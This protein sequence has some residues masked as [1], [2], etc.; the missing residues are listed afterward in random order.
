MEKQ[1]N[2]VPLAVIIGTI[3]SAPA[4]ADGLEVEANN[5]QVSA[6][7]W[8]DV[9]FD[10]N[11]VSDSGITNNA[12]LSGGAFDG[13]KG[14]V[15]SNVAAG[16]YNQGSNQASMGTRAEGNSDEAASVRAA[17]A[18][19]S[20]GEN[21]A[22][23]KDFGGDDDNSAT[24][25]GAFNEAKGII[26]TNI[27]A[28]VS[29]LQTNNVAMGN[30]E[31]ASKL[32]LT[33]ASNQS[34]GFARSEGGE[35]EGNT[36]ESLGADNVANVQGG[37]FD[38]ANGVG[39][40]NVASGMAN[41]Q[42][43]SVAL[44]NFVTVGSGDPS[45]GEAA[46]NIGEALDGLPDNTN[47]KQP[48]DNQT[49]V[50]Q[51]TLSS[52]GT[53]S[54]DGNS[55]VVDGDPYHFQNNTSFV[56]QVFN[57]V[58]GIFGLNVASGDLNAQS[59]NVTLGV[60]AL[61]EPD[62]GSNVNVNA[63][64]DQM[65]QNNSVSYT[66]NKGNSNGP[67]T[68][69]ASISN[70]FVGANGILG[71][72]AAAGQNNAQTNNVSVAVTEPNGNG[73]VDAVSVIAS[74]NQSV[75]SNSLTQTENASL[76]QVTN[77]ATIKDG[78]FSGSQ[79]IVGANA[80]AGQFN[81]QSNQVSVASVAGWIDSQSDNSGVVQASSKQT[82][83]GNSI[84][85]ADV[86]DYE[87][88]SNA[89]LTGNAL[90]NITGITG[91]NIAAGQGNAQ[92]NNV[93]MSSAFGDVDSSDVLAQSEQT[94]TQ[95]DIGSGSNSDL[96]SSATISSNFDSDVTGIM[97]VNVA[98]GQSNVQSNNVALAS[99]NDQNESTADKL[100]VEASSTQDVTSNDVFAS[101]NG[102]IDNDATINGSF[103]GGVSGVVGVNV[104]SGQANAASNNVALGLYAS[105]AQDDSQGDLIKAKAS[106]DQSVVGN[107]NTI[108]DGDEAPITNTASINNSFT[109]GVSGVVGVNNA[110]GQG[111]AQANNVAI[112]LDEAFDDGAGAGSV[113]AASNQD[114]ISNNT[115]ADITEGIA[116]DNQATLN[117]SFTGTSGIV[118]ANLSSGQ[119]NAQAN[120]VAISNGSG[121]G[122]TNPFDENG[123]QTTSGFSGVL[124]ASVQEIDGSDVSLGANADLQ[125]SE[126]N[127]A[128]TGSFDGSS[129]IV[130]ANVTAGQA[131]AQS[132]NVAMAADGQSGMQDGVLA[133]AA[134]SLQEFDEVDVSLGSGFKNEAALSG[135]FNN[136][137]KGIVGANVSSGQANAQTNNVALSSNDGQ[138]S[139]AV[140]GSAQVIG[141]QLNGAG[142]GNT[143]TNNPMTVTNQLFASEATLSDSF[144]EAKGILGV[145]V[146]SGQLNAQANNVAVSVTG[147]DAGAPT[148]AINVQ[149]AVINEV[150]YNA[151]GAYTAV[152]G[153][154]A[155]NKATGVIG[156]NLAVG[157]ANG[158]S[159]NVAMQIADGNQSGPA[160]AANIQ[161]SF[162][163][164]AATRTTDGTVDVD[165][166]AEFAGLAVESVQ[167]SS[168]AVSDDGTGTNSAL[169]S[170]GNTATINN[171]YNGATGVI[172]V[173]VASG[174]GNLQSN[175]VT[176]VAS[177]GN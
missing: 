176:L 118:G 14:V 47:N 68:N 31:D 113:I 125:V 101:G 9:T 98:S 157:V 170:V 33:A 110:A 151:T 16:F 173:N 22:M 117:G 2:K 135:S 136:G 74:S 1:W 77:N 72:N 129:G 51:V 168:F 83:A 133:A 73:P 28:G 122:A 23:Q 50:T 63:L 164:G 21:L 108:S 97:G 137:T 17:S 13:A 114:V 156:T 40:A 88:S 158:Q 126:N 8:V 107:T 93:A 39:G 35:V 20:S 153:D 5:L 169:V 140:A 100:Q 96:T 4:Y 49:E 19:G 121:G 81:A 172:G 131:N 86:G 36:I 106:S 174:L 150:N 162:A 120:N 11:N 155:F 99:Y 91:A 127:A 52:K 160:V 175:N 67:S 37:A 44:A 134:V 60:T 95:S 80:A 71:A 78:S 46:V 65:V 64:A 29:N 171:S 25:D 42:A 6:D 90:D 177:R 85:T 159:N 123:I 116:V 152:L 167:L 124:A 89:T 163:N 165:G 119:T 15:H 166:M 43:N 149:A 48:L 61:P 12:S 84:T 145:N 24:L 94:V 92:T 142:T 57:S 62:T 146:A 76:G 56:S 161:G 45:E 79:G 154:N 104:T 132:N 111:N 55:V 143:G 26:G 58:K 70:S 18:Q 87:A 53:Q 38:G 27:A 144:T 115:A 138:P 148:G 3:L 66:N 41:Q 59:N 54:L 139:V 147:T 105:N 112:A 109:G 7:N 32:T 82:V 103:T 141:A 130:G 128:L 30:A 34:L 102:Y 75:S 10:S 69:D